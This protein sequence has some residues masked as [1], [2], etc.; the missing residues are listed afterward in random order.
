M[1]TFENG[2]LDDYT[3]SVDGTDITA[4][5][6]RVDDDG[7]VVKWESTVVNP[8]M[9]T[10]ARKSDHKEQ[11]VRIG[12]KAA[13]AAPEAGSADSAPAAILANGPVLTI[14]STC[15]M[16]MVTSAKNQSVPPLI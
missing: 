11:Q 9:V 8:E 10:V 1:V 6:T 12:N 5:L 7:T 15:M 16:P 13:T 14:I 4:S 2:T 3:V